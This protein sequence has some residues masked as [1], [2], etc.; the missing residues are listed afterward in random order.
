MRFSVAPMSPLAAW[1]ARYAVAIG[2]TAVAVA[3]RSAMTPLWGTTLPF[4]FFYPAI[5]LSAWFGRLGPGI[6]A[7]F[8]SAAAAITLWLPAITA[9]S[10]HNLADVTGLVA[11][12]A[13]GI[14]LSVLTEAL[15]RTRARLA[16]KVRDLETDAVALKQGEEAFARLAAIVDSSEDAIVSKNLDGIIMT[17]NGAATRMF[18]YAADEVIGRSITILIPRDRLNEE[19]QT[20]ALIRRGEA[21][22]H[23]RTIRLRK[24]G[25][26]IAISLTVSPIK[27]AAGQIIGASKIARDISGQVEADAERTALFAREQAARQEAEAANRT[28]DEFLAMLGHELRNPLGAISNAV[29]VLERL[30]QPG[31]AT[32]GARGI[33]ARQ[34]LH[35][36]RLMDDLLDIGRVMSAKIVL[37]RKPTDL[38]EVAESAVATFRESGKVERHVVAFEGVPAWIDADATRIDQIVVNLVTNA[39]KFTPAGGAIKVQVTRTAGT[40]ELRVEDDGAGIDPDLLPRVFDLF[41]QGRPPL[42]RLQGGLGIGLSLVK[43][44]AELHGGSVEA[45]SHGQGTGTTV[46]VRLPAIAP[47]RREPEPRAAPEG[48]AARR[49]LIVEDNDD[50]RETLRTLLELSNHIVREATDGPGGI[51]EALRFQPDVAIIDVGLPGLDGYAVARY[52]RASAGGKQTRL[53]ALTGYGSSKDALRAREA[54]FDA[55]L[56][57]PVDPDRLAKIL[58]ARESQSYE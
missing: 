37:D 48:A 52:L 58:A 45:Q 15:H 47:P 6:L 39:L 42:D 27:N 44:L 38:Y 41:V 43:R 34:T 4:I 35:L 16:A 20:L 18:G 7:T 56:V 11:F 23:F 26:Q 10:V 33:L 2:A 50:A 21:I 19:T 30:G 54:G 12:V 9:M 14:L 22:E 55:H 25:T 8:L 32:A 36:S 49:V 17:W 1:L 53:V 5:M 51:E 24:D 3:I 28:K 46:I 40:A 13:I 29:H 57:K 31:D